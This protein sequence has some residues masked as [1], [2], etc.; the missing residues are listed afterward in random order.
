MIDMH[1]HSV[2]SDGSYTPSQLALKAKQSGLAGVCLADHDTHHGSAEMVKACQKQGLV[3]LW[4]IE[5][6][7]QHHGQYIHL[8]LYNTEKLIG[9]VPFNLNLMQ[10][11][12]VHQER[13]ETMLKQYCETGLIK[14]DLVEIGK[15]LNGYH[16][17][18]HFAKLY[19]YH[20]QVAGIS[21]DQA[22]QEAKQAGITK[23]KVLATDFPKAI[24]I[25]RLTKANQ[26][27]AVL[28]HPGTLRQ[29][30]SETNAQM[31]GDWLDEFL[32][33][34][35]AAGLAG[36][37][38]FHTKHSL[39]QERIFSDYAKEHDFL[40]SGGSDFHGDLTPKVN[41]GDKGL[42]LSECQKFSKR[43]RSI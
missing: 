15:C 3:S 40:I 22:R 21:F 18:I 19:Q 12:R 5:V 31:V 26:A 38:V 32:P 20:A 23:P 42:S 27:I 28:A 24:D 13:T 9:S 37:E 33:D 17:F 30:R 6:S 7:A 43:A 41:L 39:V 14:A 2:L 16:S 29:I 1:V 35:I 10:S 8:L 36:L 34:L 11:W 4:A 25:I